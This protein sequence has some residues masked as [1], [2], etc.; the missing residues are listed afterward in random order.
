MAYYQNFTV[1]YLGLT[2]AL[3]KLH[4]G[5]MNYHHTQQFGPP[6]PSPV[7]RA[8]ATAAATSPGPVQDLSSYIN[9]AANS[10]DGLGYTATS[11]QPTGF[12]HAMA[13]SLTNQIQLTIFSLSKFILTFAELN[14]VSFN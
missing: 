3:F 6:P 10:A 13:V 14:L 2:K 5:G 7:S 11:P 12:G 8:F 4:T 9:S 1:F